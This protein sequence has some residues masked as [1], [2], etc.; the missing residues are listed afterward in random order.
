MRPRCTTCP[1]FLNQGEIV[2][3]VKRCR[4]CRKATP[5]H[6]R[7]RKPKPAS[8]IHI[9]IERE[10]R[11]ERARIQRPAKPIE[12]SWWMGKDR[13]AFSEERAKLFPEVRA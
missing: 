4:I 2:Q 12:P 1:R 9:N 6:H 3:R 8:R 5:G 10:V 11:R 7:V 13:T